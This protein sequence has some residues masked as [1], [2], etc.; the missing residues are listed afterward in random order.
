MKNKL[1]DPSGSSNTNR[2]NRANCT[3]LCLEMLGAIISE[4]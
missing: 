1:D 4:I 2:A 3:N